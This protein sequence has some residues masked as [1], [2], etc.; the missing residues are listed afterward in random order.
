MVQPAEIMSL[1]ELD[2][3][4][5][6]RKVWPYPMPWAVGLH[7]ESKTRSTIKR[8]ATASVSKEAGLRAGDEIQQ[9]NGQTILSTADIQWVLHNSKDNAGLTVRY[10]REG[11]PMQSTLN[12][13]L[14]WRTKLGDWRFTNPRICMQIAGFNGRPGKNGGES[15]AIRIGRVHKKRPADIDLKRNDVIVA[16]DGKRAPMN[17]G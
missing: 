6:D 12:L 14:D 15:L 4:I 16:L 10:A 1:R 13:P 7:M 3:P 11:E 8:V 5:P 2:E 9:L 17:L